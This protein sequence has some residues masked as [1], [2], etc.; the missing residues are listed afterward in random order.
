MGDRCP[1][2]TE[3]LNLRAIGAGISKVIFMEYTIL[4]LATGASL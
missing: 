1:F 3:A 4:P 2:G